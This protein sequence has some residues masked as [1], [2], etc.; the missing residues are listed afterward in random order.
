M[1][2]SKLK[3][4]EYQKVRRARI[5]AEKQQPKPYEPVNDGRPEVVELDA[6]GNII[7]EY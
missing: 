6:D 5:K 3:Q 7:P 2:L 4:A 1:P